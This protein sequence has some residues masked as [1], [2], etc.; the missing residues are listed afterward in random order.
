M[1]HIPIVC[2]SDVRQ[3]IVLTA[4]FVNRIVSAGYHFRNRGVRIDSWIYCSYI[5]FRI[6]PVPS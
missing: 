4:F 1:P 6:R 5:Q 2:P 3:R